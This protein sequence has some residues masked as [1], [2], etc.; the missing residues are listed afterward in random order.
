MEIHRRLIEPR[1]ARRDAEHF[2]IA[3][4][5][6]RAEADGKNRR[7]GKGTGGGR[8]LTRI[9]TVRQDDDSGDALPARAFTNG[10]QRAR[11]IGLAR[12]GCEMV[13]VCWREPFADA[14]DLRLVLA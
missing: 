3:N 11:E 2:A 7:S 12:I 5:L 9:P 6:G 14:V 10:G 4:A 8:L 1:I 13:D